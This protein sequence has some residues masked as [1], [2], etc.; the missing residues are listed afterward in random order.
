MIN[1]F[2]GLLESRDTVNRV[3][4]GVI[5]AVNNQ[6]GLGYITPSGQ[7]VKVLTIEN[8]ARG[9]ELASYIPGQ[10]WRIRG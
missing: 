2:K 4:D 3:N 7:G 5:L 1:L 6:H 8:H 10:R 9:R